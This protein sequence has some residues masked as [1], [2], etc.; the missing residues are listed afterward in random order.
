[1]PESVPG[2]YSLM[3][4]L[5]QSGFEIAPFLHR[6]FRLPE[7]LELLH[8]HAIAPIILRIDDDR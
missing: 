8:R 4:S 2:P 1:M 3:G 7:R 5:G 6:A